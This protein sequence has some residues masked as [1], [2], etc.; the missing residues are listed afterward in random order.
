MMPLSATTVRRIADMLA[1]WPFE[2]IY[3]AFPGREGSDR[4]R[5]RRRTIGRA[6]YRVVERQPSR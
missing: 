5:G 2:R 4:G 6:L 1:P 3:G